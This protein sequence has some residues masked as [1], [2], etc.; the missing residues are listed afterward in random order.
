M[1]SILPHTAAHLSSLPHPNSSHECTGDYF[2]ELER[3]S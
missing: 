1:R 3:Q 2:V